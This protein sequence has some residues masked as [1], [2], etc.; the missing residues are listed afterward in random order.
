MKKTKFS[1]YF[2]SYFNYLENIP[3]NHGLTQIK[4]YIISQRELKCN[5]MVIK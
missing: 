1:L 3:R 4:N 2:L 5:N